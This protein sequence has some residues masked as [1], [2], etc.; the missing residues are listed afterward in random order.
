M[1]AVHF[2]ESFPCKICNYEA[3][4]KSTLST[5][6]KNVHQKSEQIICT[7]CNKSIQKEYLPQHMKL[8]HTAEQTQYNCK[9]C[10]F[11]TIHPGGVKKHVKNV[12][13]NKRFCYLNKI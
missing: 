4:C 12:H 1:K 3:R 11:Q 5:H 10:N 7:E 9:I 8:L 2:N 13:Q 6:V